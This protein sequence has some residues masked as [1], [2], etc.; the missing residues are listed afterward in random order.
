VDWFKNVEH[1]GGVVEAHIG[2]LAARCFNN[3][4]IQVSSI[5]A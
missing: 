3:D 4:R 2:K 5:Q 1:T